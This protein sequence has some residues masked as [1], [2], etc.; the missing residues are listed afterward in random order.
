MP[1]AIDLRDRLFLTVSEVAEILRADPR[2]VRRGI[3]AGDI[4][5]V[6][7]SS[8]VRI[9]TGPF[10]TACG[11]SPDEITAPQDDAHESEDSEES[12][13]DH[14]TADLHQLPRR[15]APPTPG[16]GSRGDPPAA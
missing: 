11:L 7:V 10:L 13:V 12:D 8:T 3:E 2:T 1:A 9:P 14:E 5:A 16:P 15:A 6:H 4:P